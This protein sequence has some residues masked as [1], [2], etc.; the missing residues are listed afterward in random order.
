MRGKTVIITGSNTGIGRATAAEL[1]RR[2][3]T[4]VFACRSRSK[5]E[6]VIEAIKTSTGNSNLHF[7][8]LDLSDLSKV[9]TSALTWLERND[10]LDV[11]V[12]NAGL[13][14]IRELT[15]QGF[16]MTFGVNHLGHL[17]FTLLLERALVRAAP[18]RVVN[19][20]SRAHERTSRPIDYAAL[21]KPLASFTG[22]PEYMRS[23]LANMLFTF[24]LDRRWRE[25]G[26][27]C[28]AVH[29][30]VIASDIWRAAPPPLRQLVML[31]MRTEEE[32]ARASVHCSASD[33]AGRE[34]G[35]YYDE[36]GTHRRPSR[37]ALD[38]EAQEK[39]WSWSMEQ[40]RPFLT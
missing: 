5:T 37:L 11:L 29:P 36:D 10:R 6:P 8:E 13:V 26:V 7:L 22:W 12:N 14:R 19:V 2:G 34:T 20:A 18:S 3:A 38:V 15:A 4:V 30:G 40:L 21:T 27:H 23:K 39:L 24:A 32:G 31:F 17:L 35:L 33:E 1:A 25:A 9:R 16:E 28:Y